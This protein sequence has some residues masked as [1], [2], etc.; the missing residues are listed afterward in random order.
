MSKSG[1]AAR[2]KRRLGSRVLGFTVFFMAL[3]L[4]GFGLAREAWGPAPPQYVRTYTGTVR[5]EKQVTV[6][7]ANLEYPLRAPADGRVEFKGQ[8][9][10][11]F[12]RW[13]VVATITGQGA[14]PG[15]S[16]GGTAIQVQAPHGGLLY[17]TVDGLEPLY[18]PD[19]FLN[20]DLAKLLAL[21]GKPTQVQEVKSGEVFGKIVDNLSPS[22][23]FVKL[24]SLDGLTLGKRFRLIVRGQRQDGTIVRKSAS[25]L[26]VV[27][28][29]DNFVNGSV[30]A[31][32]Q[33]AEW[34]FRPA[35]AGTVVPERALWQEGG[36]EGIFVIKGGVLHFQPMPVTDENGTL[37][38]IKGLAAGT[39]VVVN[40][41]SGLDGAA[42]LKN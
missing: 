2:G 3:A 21:R 8:D 28:R 11:R 23:A 30:R 5:H 29:F 15:V 14:A 24:P 18:T 16:G 41:R 10:E 9:G 12:R 39:P 13:E 19:G 6:V 1:A 36:K 20:M 31:R 42:V 32:Q 38:C 17:R 27:I 35:T 22:Y 26:G 33:T 34:E 25:P 40:P 4:S 7:F 37:A